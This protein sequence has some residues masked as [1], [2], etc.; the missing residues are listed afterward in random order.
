[1]ADVESDPRPHRI[2]VIERDERGEAAYVEGF[3]RKETPPD[4][5]YARNGEPIYGWFCFEPDGTDDAR[6]HLHE[7]GFDDE[8]INAA[9]E[10]GPIVRLNIPDWFMN[11]HVPW[12]KR[13]AHR[14]RIL[15]RR[16]RP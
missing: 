2:S 10:D 12:R 4:S 1:M 14:V 11:P 3:S 7:L 6:R 16:F 15:L 8:Q 9:L 5:G 13:V